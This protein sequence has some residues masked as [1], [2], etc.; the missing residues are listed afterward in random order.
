LTKREIIHVR[1]PCEHLASAAVTA[2]LCTL[3]RMNRENIPFF[4]ETGLLGNYKPVDY[5]RNVIVKQFLENKE[6]S[7]LWFIDSDIVPAPN[8]LQ[9]VL[10]KG[11]IVAAPYPFWGSTAKAPQSAFDQGYEHEFAECVWGVYDWKPEGGGFI[12]PGVLEKGLKEH[13]AA[14]T[15]MMIIRRHVFENPKMVFP[16]TWHMKMNGQRVE[17]SDTD[18]KPYFRNMY[19]FTGALEATEDLEFCW[20]ARQNGY[21]VMMDHGV[22]CGHLKMVN[23]KQVME[24]AVRSYEKGA[25][26]LLNVVIA[27]QDQ[28]QGVVVAA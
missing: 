17:M 16:I 10:Q 25:K 24:F 6:A 15:G 27:A 11:D 14:P 21:S 9:L 7:R 26:D 23:L 20:R 4:F 12:Q 19:Q 28:P 1:V 2:F 3:E 22:K 13:D 18:V 5:A 8:S